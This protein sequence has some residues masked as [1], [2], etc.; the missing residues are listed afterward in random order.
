MEDYYCN[1]ARLNSKGVVQSGKLLFKSEIQRGFK[2]LINGRYI[3]CSVKGR[4][5]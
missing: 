1:N 3:Q 4:C 2:G 5:L